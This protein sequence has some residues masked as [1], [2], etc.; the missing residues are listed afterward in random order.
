MGWPQTRAGGSGLFCLV[1]AWCL[2]KGPS[3]RAGWRPLPAL[4]TKETSGTACGRPG[5]WRPQPR[6]MATLGVP[7]FCALLVCFPRPGSACA[8]VRV[9]ACVYLKRSAVSDLHYWRTETA[10]SCRRML[11]PR[12]KCWDCR[13]AVPDPPCWDA[14]RS[15]V[16]GGC[17]PG[18]SLLWSRG[19]ITLWGHCSWRADRGRGLRSASKR[20]RVLMEKKIAGFY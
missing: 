4:V 14:G 8:C 13:A 6:A 16:L 12:A 11:A 10:R 1:L 17:C 5:L 3:R 7:A 2:C 9:C 20:T 15:E 18:C 19:C